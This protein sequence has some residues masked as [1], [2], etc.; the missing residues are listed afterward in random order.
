LFYPRFSCKSFRSPTF[1][2]IKERKEGKGKADGRGQRDGWKGRG[3]RKREEGRR[4][5]RLE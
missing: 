2:D 4:K 3:K 5:D 1:P